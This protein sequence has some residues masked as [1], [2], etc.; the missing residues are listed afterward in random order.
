[1]VEIQNKIIFLSYLQANYSRSG[2]YFFGLKAESASFKQIRSGFFECINDLT[3]IRRTTNLSVTSFVVMSPSHKLTIIA[4]IVLRKKIILDAGW[5]LSEA[6]W[7]RSAGNAQTKK[8]LKNYLIDFFSFHFAH[9]VILE[10][11]EELNYVAKVFL[12][13]KRKLQSVYTGFNENQYK[14]I[15]F[16]KKYRE[17]KNLQVLFRGKM[18][19]EAGIENILAA[20]AIVENEPI[21]FLIATNQSLDKYSISKNTKVSIHY[22]TDSE[23]SSIYL[24]SDVCLGQFSNSRRLNRTI[25]HKTFESLYFSKC[26]LTPATKPLLTLCDSQ[27]Q[28]LFTTT[29]NPTE[30]AEKLVF[31]E[32]NRG[33]VL[34]YGFNGNLLYKKVLNQNHLSAKVKSI[35]LPSAQM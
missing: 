22:L 27:E 23:L 12:L 35:C 14:D 30:I 31:L 26:Y 16:I 9:K 6:T 34:E 25:P 21:D 18:N 28:M 11:P 4:R 8:N 1:M 17:N 24:N 33:K 3:N 5:A 2:V 19:D 13:S 20:A 15:I 10:S 29:N 32:A 7:N